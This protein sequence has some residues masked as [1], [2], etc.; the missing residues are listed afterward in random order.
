VPLAAGPET[1]FLPDFSAVPRATLER[2]ALAILCSPA[3]PQGAIASL[4][5]LKHAI[6]LAR[7]YGFLLVV[8]ECYSEIWDRAAPP[9]ALEACQ[10]LGGGFENVLVFHSLSKRSNAAGLRAGFVAGD[11]GLIKT[12]LRMR[13][14]GASQMP[15]PLQA[16]AAAL[17]RDEAHVEENRAR[18]RRK[19]DVAERILGG[20]FGFYRPEGGFFL[21]LDVGDGEAAAK[22]LWQEAAIKTLPGGY[23]GRP[24]AEGRNP[25]A[26]YL[27]VALVH[28][29]GVIA[30]ALE[31]LAAVL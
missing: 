30:E 27:R 7:E 23:V 3:N 1:G 10:A 25:A 18:Y 9:G 19:I 2:T 14:F 29:D 26:R 8:D 5:Y 15:L 11:P 12:F 13:S 6:G 20:R 21:W 16:A 28:E 24:D 31:R 4:D 22:R 17:W